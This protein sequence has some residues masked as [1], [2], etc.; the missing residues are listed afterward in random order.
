MGVILYGEVREELPA[1]DNIEQSHEES[2][3]ISYMGEDP[4]RWT[5]KRHC[6]GQN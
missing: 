3:G 2:E 1:K 5:K 4:W 6:E